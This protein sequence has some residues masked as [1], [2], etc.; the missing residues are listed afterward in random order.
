MFPLGS[1]RGG[2]RSA[3]HP[4]YARRGRLS[5]RCGFY[6]RVLAASVLLLLLAAV[7]L[8]AQ[9]LYPVADPPVQANSDALPGGP[10]PREALTGTWNGLRPR[11]DAGGIR[12]EAAYTGEFFHGLAGGAR[13]G[14]VHLH[15]VDLTLDLNLDVLA[16]WRG[17]RVFLYGLG[18]FGGSPSDLAGDVQA[19]SNIDAPDGWRLYEAYVE[20]TLLSGRLSVLAG[21]YDLNS[22]FYASEPAALFLNGAHGMG[23]ELGL[24]GRNGPSIFPYTT[25]ALR[26]R[27]EP[28]AGIYLQAAVLDGVPCGPEQ[29]RLVPVQLSAG[30]GAL[31]IA[32]AGYRPA[33]DGDGASPDRTFA[34]GVWSYSAR[35][36]VL[37]DEGTIPAQQRSFGVYGFAQQ[38]LHGPAD[39]PRLELYARA[40]YARACVNPVTFAW[41]AGLVLTGLSPRRDA[42][43]IGL[44]VSAAHFGRPHLTAQ[45]RQGDPVPAAEVAV[46]LT[47]RLA[48]GRWLSLQPDVQ[49]VIDPAGVSGVSRAL[50]FGQRMV[51]LF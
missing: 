38:L 9:P 17:A 41:G 2:R 33:T 4:E 11:L 50:V 26:T 12:F 48:L 40:G 16:G 44:G 1:L 47:Y 45:R 25:A 51:L 34:A 46:E 20:Q 35:A 5:W 39:G 32:E 37:E 31:T 30:D 29:R 43:Q 15:D 13:R 8:T 7:P 22:E 24:S 28:A 10:V 21:L 6:Q 23:P 14:T 19:L 49:Y 18:V 27:F 3:A 36:G 42:D